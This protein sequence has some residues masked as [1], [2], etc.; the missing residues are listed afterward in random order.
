MSYA[1]DSRDTAIAGAA[2]AQQKP[3]I[4]VA[5]DVRA[6]RLLFRQ[7][8]EAAGFIVVEAENGA[9]A[10]STFERCKPAVTLLDVV[11]PV[12]DGF[13]TCAALRKT[14]AGRHAPV[15]MVTSLEDGESIQRAY[16]AGTTDFITKPVKWEIL[17]QRLRYMI[18]ADDAFRRLEESERRRAEAQRMAALGNFVWRAGMSAVE[19]SDEMRRIF[20]LEKVTGPIPFRVIFHQLPRDERK[21]LLRAARAALR[22]R[23]PLRHDLVFKDKAQGARSVDVRAE[24]VVD[25]GYRPMFQGTVQDISERKRTE[26]ALVAARRSAESA[27]AVKTA[28]LTGMN[29]ELRTPLNAIM[30]FSE[31]IASETLGPVGEPRY[32]EFANDI[33]HAGRH[34][35]D[36]VTNVLDMAKLASE[37]Y[38]LKFEQTDLRKLV[39]AA[40]VTVANMEAAQDRKVRVCDWPSPIFAK[41]DVRAVNQMLL[42]LLS[43]AVKF[44]APGTPVTVNCVPDENGDLWL[45]VI[46][47][48]I[49]MNAEETKIATQPFCQIDNRL[50][51]KY[52]GLGIGLSIVNK[53]IAGHDGRLVIDSK[54]GAG[55]RISLVFPKRLIATSSEIPSD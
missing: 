18:R 16:D 37:H 49:G 33:L 44:S 28:L 1:A 6:V 29:H 35:F 51:R 54:P 55:S 41:V 31:L 4:L 45:S 46:D 50:E 14:E 13:A 19:G 3:I 34:M 2:A 15:M 9:V 43:N 39:N 11:M 36:L 40:F 21:K 42:H 48:G 32:K 20:G 47:R 38:D 17:V 5:D 26:A 12:M 30:G 7:K 27:D 25:A 10:L 52:E 23:M 24:V 8:L 22:N 53:L